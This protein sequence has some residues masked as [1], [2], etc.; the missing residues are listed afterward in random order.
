MSGWPI[1]EPL[2]CAQCGET[3]DPLRSEHFCVGGTA[4]QYGTVRIPQE[5]AT[6]AE[7][8]LFPMTETDEP[9]Y[10][11]YMRVCDELRAR[12][13]ELEAECAHTLVACVVCGRGVQTRYAVNG[14]C[15]DCAEQRIAEL[16]AQIAADAPFTRLGQTVR[17]MPEYTALEHWSTFWHFLDRVEENQYE[18]AF[19]GA[20]AQ[21]ALDAAGVR[22]E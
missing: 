15:P 14:M 4:L 21:A 5:T 7:Q 10:N 16:R 2:R 1:I 17:N 19:A 11:E 8:E 6:R 18:V 20:T 22:A 13:A 3:I 12:I 9:V